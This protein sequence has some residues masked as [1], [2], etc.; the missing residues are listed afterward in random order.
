MNFDERGKT[1]FMYSPHSRY[2]ARLNQWK[3]LPN[4]YQHGKFVHLVYGEPYLYAVGTALDTCKYAN[5]IQIC[6]CNVMDPVWETCIPT[7]GG[8]ASR[9]Q[10]LSIKFFTDVGIFN[11]Y[12][13]LVGPNKY[14]E[15]S[16]QCFDPE[17]HSLQTVCSQQL[18]ILFPMFIFIPFRWLLLQNRAEV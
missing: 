6:R 18:L 10:D 4:V 5:I 9:L 15:F 7:K 14:D 3:K 17:T 16:I 12:I 13:Y 2:F 8:S 1:L 11:G